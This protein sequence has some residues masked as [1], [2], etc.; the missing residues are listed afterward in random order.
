[1]KEDYPARIEPSSSIQSILKRSVLLVL[2]K[3]QIIVHI[4]VSFNPHNSHYYDP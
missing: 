4:R 2:S 1:M 3:F